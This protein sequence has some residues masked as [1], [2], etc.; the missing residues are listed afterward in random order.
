MI[1]TKKE[2]ATGPDG[3]PKGIYKCAGGFGSRYLFDAKKC[4][5]KGGAVSTQ[6]AATR[7]VF[8]PNSSTVDDNRV[9]VRSPDALSILAHDLKQ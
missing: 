9:L 3:M 2:S 1:A 6:F 7:T 8:S 5:L 4:V